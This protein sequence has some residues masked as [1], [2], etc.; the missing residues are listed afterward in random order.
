M[1]GSGSAIA[2]ATA[3]TNHYIAEIASSKEVG[4]T[5]LLHRKLSWTYWSKIIIFQTNTASSY[6]GICFA[7]R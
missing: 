6:S 2:A 3:D 4:A 7:F 5:V 1:F